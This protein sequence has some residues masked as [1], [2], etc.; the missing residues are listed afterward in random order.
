M[1]MIGEAVTK[2]GAA[3]ETETARGRSTIDFPYM[4]QDDAFVVAQAVYA[5]NGTECDGDQLAAQLK[6]AAAGGGF[7]MRVIT[8][9]IFGL[10]DYERGHVRLTEL[11]VRAVDA[12][13]ARVARVESFL[14][15]P[16]FKA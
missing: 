16:L 12:K 4:D 8:S 5:V 14:A 10:L 11:G 9:R 2:E 3:P 13:Y 15:V 7:R 1:P 6:Q